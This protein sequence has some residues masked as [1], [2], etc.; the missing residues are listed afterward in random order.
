MSGIWERLIKS[1]RK[2]MTEVLGDTNAFVGLETQCTV[3]AEVV[4]ILNSRPLTHQSA[5]IQVTVNLLLRVIFCSNGKILL[6]P[7]N[8]LNAWIFTD[9]SNGEERNF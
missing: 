5:T 1:V 8:V 3:F 9:G 6:Y 2:T 4:T 7:L